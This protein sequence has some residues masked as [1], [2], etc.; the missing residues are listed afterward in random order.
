VTYSIV[1]C[2]LEAR[3]WGVAVQSKFL[4]VGAAVPFASA[5]VGAIAT[6]ALANVAY[7]PDGLALLRKG[8]TADAVVAELTSAD[9]GR[10]DRQLGV[11]DA[12]GGSASFTGSACLEWAGGRTGPCF[13]AQG[14]IL[15]S[16]ATVD[17]LAEA[18]LRSEGTP[19]VERLI[20]CLVAAQAAGGDRRGQQSAAVLVVREGGG[21]GG[22][23]DRL[24]DLRVDE[25]A[26]PIDE[27]E[28]I[29]AIH[30]TLFGETPRDQW[31]AV[32]VALRREIDARLA[33]LGFQAASTAE[34]FTAW[35]D[36]E[37]LEERIDGFDR[38]DPVV[39]EELRRAG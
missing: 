22:Q 2:D 14:N 3:E 26:L 37:N 24:V 21:Y 31:L 9:A 10:D 34:A 11:V 15:V 1:A 35:A 29:Y 7:G 39:L 16:Q 36:I 25:H 6:Q 12:H 13:A 23:S 30:R 28:R 32:D 38:I 8:Q 27:L 5:E 19:L 33:A 4:A 18:F 20:A 17:A